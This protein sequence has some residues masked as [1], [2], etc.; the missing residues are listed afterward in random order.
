MYLVEYMTN[1]NMIGQFDVSQTILMHVKKNDNMQ[2]NGLFLYS[3][4]CIK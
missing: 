4:I 3:L 1:M 2:A